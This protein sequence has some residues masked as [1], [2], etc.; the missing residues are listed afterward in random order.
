MNNIGK[1]LCSRNYADNRKWDCHGLIIDEDKEY[2]IVLDFKEDDNYFSWWKESV[3]EF[4]IKKKF[5]KNWG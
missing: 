3:I 4:K 2:Y 1:F 5:N